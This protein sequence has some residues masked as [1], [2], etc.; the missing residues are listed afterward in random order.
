VSVINEASNKITDTI[1][2]AGSTVSIAVDP[3]RANV[4]VGS[5]TGPVVSV[6]RTAR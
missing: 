2:V 3:I 1:S 4:Y 6:I 5:D